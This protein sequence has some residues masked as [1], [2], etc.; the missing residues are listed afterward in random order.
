VDTNVFQ[1]I[2]APHK[3][4]PWPPQFRSVN[5]CS[6][7][8]SLSLLLYPLFLA[9]IPPLISRKKA[10]KKDSLTV[11]ALI[12]ASVLIWS[13]PS[14]PA[15]SSSAS[16][17]TYLYPGNALIRL[18]ASSAPLVEPPCDVCHRWLD[19]T[20]LPPNSH[21]HPTPRLQHPAGCPGLD[22]R[23]DL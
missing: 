10:K 14:T 9:V 3:I 4:R 8:L 18:S 20:V 17:P 2:S 21:S 22:S 15:I 23:C 16:K 6:S 11:S 13:H 1:A 5:V 12:S 7:P 19:P